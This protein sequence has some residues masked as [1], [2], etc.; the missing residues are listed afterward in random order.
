VGGGGQGSW[1]DYYPW[2]GS[3]FNWY[4][5]SYGYGYG[6]PYGG[7]RWVWGR[8]GMWSD[9]NDPFGY[10][11]YGS[12]R[13]ESP[14]APY[15]YGYGGVAMNAYGYGSSSATEASPRA[16]TGSVRV[17]VSPRQAKVYVDGTL[18]GTV[19]EFDGLRN[20]LATT[21]GAHEIEIR[22]DGYQPLTLP[23]NV[24]E[25]KTVTV[26]GSLKKN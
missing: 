6:S 14:Y 25:D 23:V 18:M 15:G 21:A 7:S 11:G 17:R 5:P 26:R 22:A 8:Y 19:D 12:Y 2:Y 20:H 1:S 13:A 10:Y 24:D 16:A 4:Y 9:L 3:G